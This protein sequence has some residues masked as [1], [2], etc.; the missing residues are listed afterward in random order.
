LFIL[1]IIAINPEQIFLRKLSLNLI[2]FLK[3]NLLLYSVIIKKLQSKQ[4]ISPSPYCGLACAI[5]CHA[6]IEM[7][8]KWVLLKNCTDEKNPSPRPPWPSKILRKNRLVCP[9]QAEYYSLPIPAD[10]T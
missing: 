3:Y 7:A 10:D 8:V 6:S 1:Q 5:A 9:A 4:I 2:I